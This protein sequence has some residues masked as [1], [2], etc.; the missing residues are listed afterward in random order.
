ML[1]YLSSS[2][3]K[4]WIIQDSNPDT[5]IPVGK[6]NHEKI[7]NNDIVSIRNSNE[8]SFKMLQHTKSQ[9]E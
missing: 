5:A 3:K 6:H 8:I 4:A 2:D 9:V 1:Y 7:I